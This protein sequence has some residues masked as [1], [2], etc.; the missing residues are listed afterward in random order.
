MQIDQQP[1]LRDDHDDKA[2]THRS[3]HVDPRTKYQLPNQ[4][5]R[6]L[7][8]FSFRSH[9]GN[10][11]VERPS[12]S[13]QGQTLGAAPRGR[14]APRPIASLPRP[15]LLI[16]MVIGIIDAGHQYEVSKAALGH[17]AHV[18]KKKGY[19]V[20]EDGMAPPIDGDAQRNGG[21][22]RAVDEFNF[23]AN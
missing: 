11:L 12:R 18:R 21:P 2:P 20:V 8:P 1:E 19:L 5:S 6:K 3:H 7:H 17:G 22:L 4:L 10:R 16:D 15:I 9:T 23:V 13:R 14:T